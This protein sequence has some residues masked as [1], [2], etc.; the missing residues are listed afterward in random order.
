MLYRLTGLYASGPYIVIG[1]AITGTRGHF[2]LCN[3]VLH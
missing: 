3:D 2:G 1:L